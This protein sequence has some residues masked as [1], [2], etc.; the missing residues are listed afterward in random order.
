MG[1]LFFY[2]IVLTTTYF[3]EHK[4]GTGTTGPSVALIN[5]NRQIKIN[6]F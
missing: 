6:A 3:I 4:I 2:I 1:W 5:S